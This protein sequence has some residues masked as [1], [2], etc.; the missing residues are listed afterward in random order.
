MSLASSALSR[1]L[2][3]HPTHT[4][5]I[6][7]PTTSPPLPS[8]PPLSPSS[9]PPSPS[10]APP[11]PSSLPPSPSSPPLSP[12]SPPPSSHHHHHHPHR[13]PTISII[14]PT[15]S[16]ITP[17][18]TL[19]LTIIT[20][21]VTIVIPVVTT[22]IMTIITPTVAPPSPPSP[23]LSPPPPSPSSPLLSPS[24]PPSPSSP[25]L[26]PSSPHH[27]HRHPDRHKLQCTCQHNTCGGTCDRC[28]PG[29]NQQP[30]KPATASSANECQSCNCHGHATDCYYDPEVDRRRASQSMDG[31]YQGGGVC[32]DCQHHTTGINCERCLP[33]FYRSPDHPLDSPYVCRR[34][35]CE[36]DFTDGTCEDLTGRCYCRP[37][38]SGEQCDSCAE[39]F[40]SFPNCYRERL[41]GA[42]K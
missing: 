32:I 29:F 26:S 20:F 39:G 34:C 4:P 42:S 9:P 23:P 6:I 33:G 41:Q 18:V 17:T 2:H 28:C 24:P 30:W 15:I 27:H 37:R 22:P 10:S 40:T 19:T 14:T 13:H 31:T 11:S 3:H 21:T 38:F 1:Y 5:A 36:S 25:S 7:T 16:I 12:S 35:S 8:S